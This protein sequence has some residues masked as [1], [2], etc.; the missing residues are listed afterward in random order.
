MNDQRLSLFQIEDALVQLME[1]REEVTDPAEVEQVELAIRQYVEAEVR[2]VDGIR[3]Y[4]RHCVLMEAGAR[5]EAAIQ[6]RRANAWAARKERL[7]E[8]CKDVMEHAQVKSLEGNTGRLRVQGNGG[9]LPLVITDESQVPEECCKYVGWIG[10]SLW[11]AILNSV[12]NMG[13]GRPG[14]YWNDYKME[15]VVDGDRVRAALP[16]P[17]A[18][19][20]ER[21]THLRVE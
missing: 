9:V 13:D 21:G 19:L 3:G 15:R 2:K 5:E 11:H 20:G 14:S 6:S 4:L 8:M 10:G 18:H 1:A 16:V 7:K 12:T 17:G